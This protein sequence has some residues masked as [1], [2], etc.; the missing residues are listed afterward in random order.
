M[1]DLRAAIM[2]A[3]QVADRLH[4]EFGTRARADAGE[5]RVDVFDMLVQKD[6][7]TMFRKLDKLLGAFLDESGSKGVIVT[8][9]RQLPVQRY[10]AA[11]ELG[12]AMLGHQPSADMEDILARSPFVDRED[13]RYAVQEIEANV[14]ASCLLTP[15]WLLVKHMLQQ[16]WSAADVANPDTV[17]QLSLRLGASYAATCHAL[18]HHKVLGAD[19]CDQLLAVK[20]RDI[21]KRLAAPYEP[22][23]WRRDVWLITARDDGVM[24][25]GSRSDLVVVKLH[26][27]SGSGYLWRLDELEGAGLAVVNDNRVADPDQDL[28]GGVVFRTVISEARD[29]ALGRVSIR[30]VRPWLTNGEPLHSVNLGVD[31]SGPEQS[32]LYKAQRG[33]ALQGAA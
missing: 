17:Y 10:T 15:R 19:R 22:S 32:G 1:A 8:T 11:H 28:V 25:E 14:F 20:R 4:L 18:Q 6:I 16:G 7:P 2:G 13:G 24:L 3:V 27:H 33:K 21:K 31:F 5:G 23:D 30:E 26:E 9:Q 29:G 12:H